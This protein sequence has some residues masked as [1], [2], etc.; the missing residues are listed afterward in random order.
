MMFVGGEE[1]CIGAHLSRTCGC[2][3]TTFWSLFSLST[4][5]AKGWIQVVRLVGRHFYQLDRLGSL[6]QYFF[7]LD[8]CLFLCF[9]AGSF[10]LKT[11]NF[12]LLLCI[13]CVWGA[14]V[15]HFSCGGERTVSGGWFSPEFQETETR[16]SSLLSY[17]TH[18]VFCKCWS[19]GVCFVKQGLM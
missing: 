5:L 13:I 3:K 18:L 16:P 9:E 8:H 11:F 15:C 7:F 1:L 17:F 10:F 6:L 14:H 4:L 2:Q 12:L 19:A